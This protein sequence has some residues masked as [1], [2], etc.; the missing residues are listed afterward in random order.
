MGETRSVFGEQQ[1]C[2]NCRITKKN[3]EM[4]I[5]NKQ[6][7]LYDSK[8]FSKALQYSIPFICDDCKDEIMPPLINKRKIIISTQGDKQ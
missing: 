1:M 8:I 4:N 7:K 5:I 3:N 6:F 2:I